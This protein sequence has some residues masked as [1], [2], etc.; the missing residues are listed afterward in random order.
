MSYW[1]GSL[2]TVTFGPD[3]L[4]FHL[5]FALR[6]ND[7]GSTEGQTIALTRHRRGPFGW[8][9]SKAI[10][11][12]TVVA[13]RYFAYGDTRVFQTIRFRFQNPIAADRAVI[14]FIRHLEAQ[15]LAAW[16][17]GEDDNVGPRRLHIAATGQERSIG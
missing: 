15:P 5:M 10:L 1:Y 11:W 4:Q 9:I 13:A 2:G 16:S 12:F 3:F 6:R 14:A 7:D 17:G 8:L